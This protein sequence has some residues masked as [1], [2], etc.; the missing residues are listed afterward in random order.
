MPLMKVVEVKKDN[1]YILYDADCIENPELLRF[2]AD[3]WASQNAIT[4][5]AEGRGT[6]FF[7]Q[8]A[9]KDYVL[10]HYRRGGMIARLSPDQYIWTGLR[11]TRAWREWHLLAQMQE[12]GLPVPQ[13]V[14]TQVVRHGLRYSADI[15]TRRINHV[16]TLADTLAQQALPMESWQALGKIIRR[17]H[18]QGVWHADLN[19]NNILLNDNKQIFLIDFDRGRLRSPAHHW[20][21]ANLD[22][23]KRSLLKLQG[24]SSN[25]YFTA[26]DWQ[27][28]LTGYSAE[29]LD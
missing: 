8:H 4:G 19:A 22:R 14:A 1:R 17:F 6:T 13:P 24:R 7:I 15:M 23:L 18:Q 5:F 29:S 26:S 12:M 25:F 21:Q 20:Q 16:T 2:D 27:A 10:R 28:L 3:Y 11:R 9:D